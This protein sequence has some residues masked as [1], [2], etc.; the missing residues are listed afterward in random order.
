MWSL[1]VQNAQPIAAAR[2]LR[3]H[4]E[5]PHRGLTAEQRDEVAALHVWMAPAWQEKI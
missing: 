1:I 3:A 5:R 4:G 2:L